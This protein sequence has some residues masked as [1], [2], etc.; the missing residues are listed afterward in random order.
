MV[1][2]CSRQVPAVPYA[3]FQENRP[4]EKEEGMGEVSN[5]GQAGPK[6]SHSGSGIGGEGREGRRVLGI[7]G[8]LVA[9]SKGVKIFGKW[10]GGRRIGGREIDREL[11]K[12]AVQGRRGM[13]D[14]EG[15]LVVN[16]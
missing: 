4:S 1:V 5:A 11:G 14:E 12:K 8:N 6:K 15:Y 13:T 3:H 7:R 16:T 10:M 9:P 2:C